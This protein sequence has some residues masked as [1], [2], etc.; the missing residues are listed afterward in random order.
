[1]NLP[2]HSNHLN[3]FVDKYSDSCYTERSKINAINCIYAVKVDNCS[4]NLFNKRCLND[5]LIIECEG[6]VNLKPE[7]TFVCLMDRICC[8]LWFVDLS[9]SVC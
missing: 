2:L 9:K 7:C 6:L 4:V 8:L 1:M 3:V 5:L